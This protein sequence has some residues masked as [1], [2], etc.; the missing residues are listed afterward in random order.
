LFNSELI[1]QHLAFGVGRWA[2]DIVRTEKMT[3]DL[4]ADEVRALLNLEP[5]AT[6]GIVRV[7]FVSEKH[8]AAGGLPAPFAEGGPTSS[9]LYFVVT[10]DAPVRLHRIRG[11]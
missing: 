5:H 10:P 4:T 6:C 3:G 8:I 9:A 11:D 7:T 2:S 1:I